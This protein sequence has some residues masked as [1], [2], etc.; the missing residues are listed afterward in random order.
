MISVLTCAKRGQYLERTIASIDRAGGSEYSGPK[1]IHVDGPVDGIVGAP[2]WD[3]VSVSP[4][5]G[6]AVRALLAIAARALDLQAEPLLYFEDDVIL[7]RNAIPAMLRIGVPYP[8]GLVSYC[9]LLWHAGG[10]PLELVAYPGCPRNFPVADGG[11]VGCQALALAR[12]TLEQL[13]AVGP[14][15]WV[16]RHNCDATIGTSCRAYGI[17]DSLADHIGAD[18]AIMGKRYERLRGVR[19]WRGEDFDASAIALPDTLNQI[20]ERCP[21]HVGVLHDSGRPCDASTPEHAK[22]QAPPATPF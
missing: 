2:G 3:V 15:A 20:G 9:D 5:G 10:R 19:G 12:R 6:S 1:F 8:L 13:V 11:F 18:S 16:D 7:C 14:P 22:I 21:L 17:V 4:V